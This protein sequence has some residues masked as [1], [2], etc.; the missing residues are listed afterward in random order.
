MKFK[1]LRFHFKCMEVQLFQF[2]KLKGS[3]LLT[4]YD[5][6][7]K[8][9][10][11]ERR[12]GESQ[13]SQKSTMK[14]KWKC[15]TTAKYKSKQVN[16]TRHK[17]IYIIGLLFGRCSAAIPMPFI[18]IYNL[19]FYLNLIFSL[20]LLLLFLCL[21]FFLG[22]SLISFSSKC[23]SVLFK[24]WMLLILIRSAAQKKM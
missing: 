23:V 4:S 15:L 12:R 9:N 22:A 21:Q 11:N 18:Y 10:P 14:N 1:C 6:G 7:Q 5:N 20:L 19:T 24:I 3:H 8:I 2:S 13:A 16:G 17:I